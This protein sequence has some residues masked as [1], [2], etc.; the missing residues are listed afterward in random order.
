MPVFRLLFP[1]WEGPSPHRNRMVSVS[2]LKRAP[3]ACENK[4]EGLLRLVQAQGNL[5]SS[6]FKRSYIFLSAGLMSNDA[7][8]RKYT[9]PI[10]NKVD[11]NPIPATT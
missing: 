5:L 10:S 3:Q 1:P 4:Q 9:V 11:A 8:V 2:I 7:V 6:F